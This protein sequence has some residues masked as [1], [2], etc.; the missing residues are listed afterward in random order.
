MPRYCTERSQYLPS[1]SSVQPW[2]IRQRGRAR[3]GTLPENPAVG[4]RPHCHSPRAVPRATSQGTQSLYPR[5]HP[6]EVLQPQEV[7]SCLL[8]SKEAVKAEASCRE[9]QR[10]PAGKGVASDIATCD[11][12]HGRWA[13]TAQSTCKHLTQGAT[14]EGKEHWKTQSHLRPGSAG[15]WQRILPPGTSEGV[16][17]VIL[18]KDRFPWML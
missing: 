9:R 5:G 6:A 3:M 10:L 17:G 2:I 4:H 15:S 14:H 13:M 18:P 1:S 11:C 8:Q 12:P 7:S 16:Q